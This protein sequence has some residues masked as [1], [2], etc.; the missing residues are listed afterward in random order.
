MHPN[1]FWV[2]MILVCGLEKDLKCMLILVCRPGIIHGGKL[3]ERIFHEVTNLKYIGG[4][5]CGRIFHKVTN[6]KYI[7][8]GVSYMRG[9]SMK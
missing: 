8:M 7:I 3:Y 1:H 4:K 9:Y 2:I 6:L 5:L